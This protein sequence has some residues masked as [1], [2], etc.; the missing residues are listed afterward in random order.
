[1]AQL[2]INSVP[3]GAEVNIGGEILGTTP[4]TISIDE[5]GLEEFR[6]ECLSDGA[7]A[8]T[9]DTLKPHLEDQTVSR[10]WWSLT[11]DER[12]SITKK[13]V[14]NNPYGRAIGL[15][16]YSGEP[17]CA[18]HFGDSLPG[19]C[20]P[21]AAI[22]Y[23][24]FGGQ[25]EIIDYVGRPPTNNIDGCYFQLPNSNIVQCLRQ[26]NPYYLPCHFVQCINDAESRCHILSAIL[27]SNTKIND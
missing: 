4:L 23:T 26:P 17:Y 7:V 24:K 1:M 6:A 2:L 20:A 12:Y 14:I 19:N 5:A 3:A 22:R 8:C 25:A 27:C 18:G 9:W 15:K 21:A 16:M 11:Q 10:L 13:A